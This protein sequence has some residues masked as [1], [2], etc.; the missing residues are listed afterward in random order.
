MGSSVRM[1][2]WM[3]ACAVLATVSLS[4][5][6]KEKSNGGTFP[7]SSNP[8]SNPG[9]GKVDE[10]GGFYV[11]VAS[12]L[13]I[14]TLVHKFDDYGSACKIE[15]TAAATDLLCMVNVREQDLHFW[16]LA[17]EV[18]L[19][20]NMCK[21]LRET[22]YFYYNRPTGFGPKSIAVSVN[23]SGI[24]TGCTVD[25]NNGTLSG[26]ICTFPAGDG[27]VDASGVISC[28]Y[29]Y[30]ADG[31][32]NCC[33]GKYS[34][35]VATPDGVSSTSGSYGGKYGACLSGPATHDDWLKNKDLWPSALLQNVLETGYNNGG[36]YTIEAPLKVFGG[37][38]NVYAA[39]F[40]GWTAYTTSQAAWLAATRPKAIVP[41]T[42]LGLNPLK[43]ANE[44][45][46]Y[47]CLD[48]SGEVKHRIRVY[49]N[50][51][52]TNENFAAYKAGSGDKTKSP[53][54][55]PTDRDGIECDVGSS[56]SG[57]CDDYY[58]WDRLGTDYPNEVVQ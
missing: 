21:Y 52:D 44:A 12:T 57:L 54:A 27:T 29:D 45:Y 11:K 30:S 35:S 5:C 1:F 22:P 26:T 37:W 25:G 16:G 3:M 41:V 58:D 7:E 17:F 24:V 9:G 55:A 6:S 36:S 42:D 10:S 38:K 20:R 40:F 19:P 15:S 34:V 49:V 23:A 18:N 48:E 39:N 53:N 56:V 13:G 46:M 51:W 31:G 50:E 2:L 33:M 14:S 28:A 32:A 47:E 8:P 43:S 4:A